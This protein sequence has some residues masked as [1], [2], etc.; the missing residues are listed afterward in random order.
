MISENF[1]RCLAKICG[2]GNM[3][4]KY[5][6]YSNTSEILLN[7]FKDDI[8][9]EF[10]DVHF[11]VGKVNSGTSFIQIQ[12]KE[13]IAAFS[14][15]LA[16]FKS[17]EIFIPESVKNSPL[18]VKVAFARAFYDDEG[19]AALRFNEPTREWK[20]NITL[21]SNS[22][23]I[24]EGIK[25][26][27][28]SLGISS[29]RIYR[30]RANSSY[31]IS[32][33]LGITGRRNLLLFQEKIGFKHPAKAAILDLIIKSYGATPKR[34]PFLYEELKKKKMNLAFPFD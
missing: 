9:K 6:R 2:D 26:L 32:F 11:T 12:K 24:L 10:G 16:S 17:N 1:A 28:A 3:N 30:N 19:C 4:S 29:N 8:R 7:E 13:I 33:I 22:L 5:I 31:D 27:L 18:N 34:N 15:N 14:S 23:R 25:E 21:C 20:R